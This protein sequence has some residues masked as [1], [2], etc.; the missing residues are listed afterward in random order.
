MARL[1]ID[2]VVLRSARRNLGDPLP[3]TVDQPIRANRSDKSFRLTIA[4]VALLARG[5]SM[6]NAIVA[7]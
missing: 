6:I 3:E 2:E 1:V 4:R 7:H 5:T